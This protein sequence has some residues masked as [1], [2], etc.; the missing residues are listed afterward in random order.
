[1]T[2]R[3]N[4]QRLLIATIIATGLAIPAEG[5]RQYA[6]HDAKGVLSVCYGS[7]SEVDPNKKYTLA[8]CKA[9]LDKD[10]GNAI[11]IVEKCSPGLPEN[12]LAA[13]ADAV[14][15]LGPVVVCDATKST[16]ARKLKSGD[17]IGAC[18]ELTKWVK[19]KVMGQAVTLPGLVKRR[20]RE[21]E[22]CLRG[23]V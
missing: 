18:N 10:I 11:A 15:N 17:I 4:P 13:F 2:N 21:K 16:L 20:E 9:R 5:I 12:Q 14:Y 3:T 6:Y 8:E 19:V 22:L 1:M 7:T 23:L